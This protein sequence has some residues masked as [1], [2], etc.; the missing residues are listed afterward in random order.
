MCWFPVIQEIT[1]DF[2]YFKWNTLYAITS[3]IRKFYIK[4]VR[5]PIRDTNLFSTYRKKTKVC[6]LCYWNSFEKD[7]L[8]VLFFNYI[9]ANWNGKNFIF[10]YKYKYLKR[11]ICNPNTCV[12]KKENTILYNKKRISTGYS[13]W[14]SNFSS[15]EY[16]ETKPKKIKHSVII[17]ETVLIANPNTLQLIPKIPK[18]NQCLV[19]GES[20]NGTYKLLPTVKMLN[21]SKMV[22]SRAIGYVLFLNKNL[23]F[24]SKMQ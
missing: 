19:Y 14:I 7:I 15:F 17:F 2:C 12:R 8:G 6:Y 9:L 16:A 11:W 18:I 23:W 20:Y 13:F 3:F 1:V 22:E 21:I 24:F 4:N 5:H 10:K